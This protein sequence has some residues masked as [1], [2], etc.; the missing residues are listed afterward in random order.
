MKYFLFYGIFPK[1]NILYFIVFF[2]T[3]DASFV[4]LI[5]KADDVLLICLSCKC[6]AHFIHIWII[7][8]YHNS[9]C[10]SYHSNFEFRPINHESIWD[11]PLIYQDSSFYE[12]RLAENKIEKLKVFIVE[13]KSNRQ[14]KMKLNFIL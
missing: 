1:S 12:M 4:R 3:Q 11:I 7:D 14:K 13:W 9:F 5:L 2:I 6:E 8:V 10:F